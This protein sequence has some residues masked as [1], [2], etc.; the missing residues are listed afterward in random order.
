MY[1]IDGMD[2]CVEWSGGGWGVWNGPRLCG[3]DVI[4]AF[5]WCVLRSRG[6]GPEGC[7]VVEDSFIV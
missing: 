3:V 5:M 1:G 2:G 6:F 4:C 7:S